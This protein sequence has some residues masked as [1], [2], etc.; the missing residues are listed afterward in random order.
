MKKGGHRYVCSN[1][2]SKGCRAHV[3][4]SCDNEIVKAVT[5]HNHDRPSYLMTE[6][7][8]FMRK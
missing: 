3:H 7:G 1:T 2:L 8:C 6:D 5:D 4:V